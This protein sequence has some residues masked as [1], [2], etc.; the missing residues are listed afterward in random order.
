M[1]N[2]EKQLRRYLLFGV[3]KKEKEIERIKIDYIIIPS[4]TAEELGKVTTAVGCES[5]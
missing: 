5:L 3:D 4:R 1:Y 2:Y